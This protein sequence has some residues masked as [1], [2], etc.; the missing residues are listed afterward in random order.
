M[1]NNIFK[2]TSVQAKLLA[3]TF[4][5]YLPAL[6]TRLQQQRY[7][8]DTMQKYLHAVDAFGHWLDAQQLPLSALC[9]ETLARYVASFPR[10][11]VRSCPQGV[12]PHEVDGLRHLLNLLRAQQLIAPALP[13]TATTPMEQLLAAYDQH[14]VRIIGKMNTNSY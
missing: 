9:E 4:G 8:L 11:K 13:A 5:P 1:I 10:R 7:A 12:Q 14:L 3:G 6:V 2:R